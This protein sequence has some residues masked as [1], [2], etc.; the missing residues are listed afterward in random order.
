MRFSAWLA[1]TDRA[2]KRPT[3]NTATIGP[4][5]VV[6]RFSAW[7]APTDRALKR[8]TTNTAALGPSFVVMRFSAWSTNHAEQ[9]AEVPTSRH[10]TT[11][12]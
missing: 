9:G 11:H 8:P 1:L 7:L 4:A 10:L 3:T 5:F 6:M 12:G 2:L